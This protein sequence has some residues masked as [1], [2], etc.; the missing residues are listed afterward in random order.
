MNNSEH[1]SG[2]ILKYLQIDCEKFFLDLFKA[3][4][5]FSFIVQAT[6]CML[7]HYSHFR[8]VALVVAGVLVVG[9]IVM[10]GLSKYRLNTAVCSL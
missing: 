7:V 4:G 10:T 8:N 2:N 6:F 9:T 5:S 3:I 1:S